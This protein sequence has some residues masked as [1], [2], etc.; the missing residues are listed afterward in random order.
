[1]TGGKGDSHDG[2]REARVAVVR[3]PLQEEPEPCEPAGA[4]WLPAV[5]AGPLGCPGHVS[6]S[7]SRVQPSGGPRPPHH[8]RPHPGVLELHLALEQRPVLFGGWACSITR[9]ESYLFFLPN[10]FLFQGIF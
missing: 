5:S 4:L 8:P 3:V 6:A 2:L 7:V 1:M 9:N 10:I